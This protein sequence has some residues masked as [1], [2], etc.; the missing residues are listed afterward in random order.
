MPR[1]CLKPML[2]HLGAAAPRRRLTSTTSTSNSGAPQETVV[3]IP[4]R[5]RFPSCRSSPRKA[6]FRASAR[7][8]RARPAA[9]A[10]RRPHPPV[11]GP[12]HPDR[13]RRASARPGSDA[14]DRWPATTANSKSSAGGSPRASPTARCGLPGR[15]TAA[16]ALRGLCRCGRLLSDAPALGGDVRSPRS[17][18]RLPGRRSFWQE[19]ARFPASPRSR[20]RLCGPAFSRSRFAT[21]VEQVLADP[22]A[23]GPPS[24]RDTFSEQH[25]TDPDRRPARPPI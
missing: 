7:L 11:E 8:L 12:R 25:D 3:K 5:S 6:A 13:G 22:E 15:C 20:R 24:A 1:S 17:R 9:A 18:Q 14:R 10:I 23:F 4:F 2:A 19:R 16:R 21:Q